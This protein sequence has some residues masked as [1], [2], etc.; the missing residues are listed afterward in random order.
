MQVRKTI[1]TVVTA[2]IVAVLSLVG[3]ALVFGFTLPTLPAPGANV[4][5]PIN[6]LGIFQEK[7]GST[8]GATLFGEFTSDPV[9]IPP[10]YFFDPTEESVLLG[11]EDPLRPL[12]L[13]MDSDGLDPQNLAHIIDVKDPVEDQDAAT[14][15]YVDRAFGNLPDF[16]VQS[17]VSVPVAPTEADPYTVDATIVNSG[18]QDSPSDITARMM[19]GGSELCSTV[20]TAATMISGGS[21]LLSCPDGPRSAGV[22][23]YTVEV[24]T[25]DTV[26]E[27]SELNNTHDADI[28]V[29]EAPNLVFV[30]PINLGTPKELNSVTIPFTVKNTGGSPSVATTVEIQE[31]NGTV[32]CSVAI[33]T[34]AVNEEVA[35]SC[36]FTDG[37]DFVLNTPWNGG[38]GYPAPGTPEQV[39]GVIDPGTLVSESN[40]SDNTVLTSYFTV[41]PLSDLKVQ[42]H[43]YRSTSISILGDPFG[44]SQTVTALRVRLRNNSQYSYSGSPARL[45]LYQGNGSP[46]NPY[47]VNSCWVSGIGETYACGPTINYSALPAG[48]PYTTGWRY[49][50]WNP[51]G[52]QF[53]GSYYLEINSPKKFNETNMNNNQRGI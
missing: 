25:A 10:T 22:Y 19:Y 16:A 45:T 15:I 7:T 44:G 3:S 30:G 28:E 14:K 13:S 2:S 50:F 21:A 9:A 48:S 53:P 20:I 4:A 23:Q 40:E 49:T 26:E 29:F 52:G 12:A 34:L 38:D 27:A 39:Q 18:P 43:D 8:I 5:A 42:N 46:A 1:R 6:K 17:V 32:L 51:S 31:L 41:G 33:P 36:V 37:F 24:D 35:T 47:H 11:D